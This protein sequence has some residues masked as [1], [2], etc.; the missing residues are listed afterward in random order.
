MVQ[1]T[2]RSRTKTRARP[3]AMASEIGKRRVRRRRM[4]RVCVIL[5]DGWKAAA[6]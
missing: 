2:V 5:W 6:Y 1:N 3:E 4:A